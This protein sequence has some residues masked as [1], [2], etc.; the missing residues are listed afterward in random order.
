[1]WSLVVAS[2]H[3]ETYTIE[4]YVENYSRI[5]KSVD[6]NSFWDLVH[7]YGVA[8]TD[9]EGDLRIEMAKRNYGGGRV[10]AALPDLEDGGGGDKAEDDAMEEENDAKEEEGGTT[11]R[12]EK[13]Y[14]NIKGVPIDSLGLPIDDDHHRPVLLKLDVEGHELRALL[15]GMQFL[16][17]ANIVYAMTE[18]RPTFHTDE[19]TFASW[20][21]IMGILVSKGLVPYRIDYEEETRLDVS[22]LHE[23]RHVKHPQVRYFDVVWRKDG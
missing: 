4:P 13:E 5:C 12:R 23:W 3:R 19:D 16:H 8:A 7:L 20:K 9:V 17:R 11:T 6:K 10:S 22:R 1:M 15:G 18:L 14:H 21:K 2:T